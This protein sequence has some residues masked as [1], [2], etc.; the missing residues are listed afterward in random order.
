MF[1][2]N[3]HEKLDKIPVVKKAICVGNKDK[4]L[5]PTLETCQ[6]SLFRRQRFVCSTK[7]SYQKIG[8][9]LT[10]VLYKYFLEFSGCNSSAYCAFY[11]TES[12]R[13]PVKFELLFYWYNLPYQRPFFLNTTKVLKNV[14]MNTIGS[15]YWDMGITVES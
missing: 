3:A 15:D 11:S 10:L 5:V 2:W 4:V 13:A 8:P 1:L 6:Y 7:I 9:K 14:R 12:A